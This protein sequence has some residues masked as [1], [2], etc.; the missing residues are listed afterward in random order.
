M[1]GFQALVQF[2]RIRFE[3]VHYTTALLSYGV[4]SFN[5]L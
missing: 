3:T 5:G 4:N 2:D 1:D